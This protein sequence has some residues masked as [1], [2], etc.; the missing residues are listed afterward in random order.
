MGFKRLSPHHQKASLARVTPWAIQPLEQIMLLVFGEPVNKS[1]TENVYNALHGA[2]ALVCVQGLHQKCTV[3]ASAMEIK[4]MHHR[5]NGDF[6]SGHIMRSRLPTMVNRHVCSQY[7]QVMTPTSQVDT[8]S[9]PIFK[10]YRKPCAEN[11]ICNGYRVRVMGGGDLSS[12]AQLIKLKD[13]LHGAAPHRTAFSGGMLSMFLNASGYT[14]PH[15][16]APARMNRRESIARMVHQTSY[17]PAYSPQT[18]R[19]VSYNCCPGWSQ[20]SK[21]SH[22]CGRPLCSSSCQ[23]GGSCVRPDSCS[24]AKGFTGSS[25]Q[26]GNNKYPSFTP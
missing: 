8:Y 11:R 17:R 14:S 6:E 12:H 26:T 22:G 3:A 10:P 24:C 7:T 15:H 18:T 23:N 9:K 21:I 16:T 5:P 20:I 19:Q 4:E 1:C 2:C 13:R 25:C